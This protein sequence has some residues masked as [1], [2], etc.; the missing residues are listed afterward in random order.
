M[1]NQ[2]ETFKWPNESYR[3]AWLINGF[4]LKTL[5]GEEEKELDRWI[6]TS[7]VNMQLFEDLTREENT[8]NFLKWY[9]SINT[10]SRLVEVKK[11]IRFKSSNQ[12][13]RIFQ[14][15]AAVLALCFVANTVYFLVKGKAEDERKTITANQNDITP[16]TERAR[17]TLENGLVIDLEKG[18]DTVINDYIRVN[19]GEVSYMNKGND[20]GPVYHEIKIP[21][22]GFYKLVLPD[23]SRVWLNAESSIRYPAAFSGDIREVSVTGETYFEVAKDTRRPFIVSVNGISVKALGTAFNINAYADEPELRTTLV[24][25][26]IAIEQGEQS[27][28]LAP[29]EQLRIKGNNWKKQSN[30]E[31]SVYTSWKDNVFKMKDAEIGEVMRQI[32]RWYDASII[33]EEIPDRH[34]NGTIER[35]VPV[36]KLLKLLEG[37]G[38]VHFKVEEKRITISK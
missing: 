1:K 23:G 32:A 30:V 33:Y 20:S 4:L 11:R 28:I 15:A 5:T 8:G 17:L 7:E 36:S 3:T 2:K 22:K 12:L 10:E 37:T 31:T 18:K 24:E 14:L 26:S 16:G 35:D 21:R 9:A 6:L 38:D 25:G 13:P 19:N 27:Q 29:G 34:F